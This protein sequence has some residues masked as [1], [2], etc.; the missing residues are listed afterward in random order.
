MATAIKKMKYVVCMECSDGT[1]QRAYTNDL[2]TAV[3]LAR[4][5]RSKIKRDAFIR[6]N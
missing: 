5:F 1:Y 6:L 2:E 3:G 4:E